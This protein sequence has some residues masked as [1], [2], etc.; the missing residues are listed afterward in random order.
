MPPIIDTEGLRKARIIIK[1]LSI[2][3]PPN[4]LLEI[5]DELSRLW[6]DD[7]KVAELIRKDIGLA[8]NILKTINSSAFNL[9]AEIM[10][11]EH[12]IRLM[13]LK[14]L[15]DTIIRVALR[16]A[17]ESSMPEFEY[18]SE[19]SHSVGTN[20]GVIAGHFETIDPAE[21]Y[22]AGL[23]HEAGS[24]FLMQRFPEYKSFYEE[25]RLQALSLPNLERERFG[26]SHAAISFL[27]AKHW[28]L[29]ENVCHAIY[30]HHTVTGG[31]ALTA[32]QE[33]L[34][35]ALK[36]ASYITLTRYLGLETEQS[37]ESLVCR[38]NSIK[39][40]MI[41]QEALEEIM[42]ECEGLN[43]TR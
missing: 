21:A 3:T 10:S 15:K 6:P 32:E 12:A 33:G 35:S 22:M 23:F 5:G 36:L 1:G 30:F 28:K 37:E 18:L 17:L 38:D 11:I 20:A 34:C 13:G 16:N 29:P 8:S 31:I 9:R 14:Q 27:L 25:N 43:P 4:L 40:L 41:D 19:V 42:D 24:I 2:P 39:E 26:A 7:N